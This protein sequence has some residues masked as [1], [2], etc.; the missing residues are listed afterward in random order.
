MQITV[1]DVSKLIHLILILSSKTSIMSKEY[2][3]SLV[4][5]N[6]DNQDKVLEVK[7][8]NEAIF[9]TNV[10]HPD[11]DWLR[12]ECLMLIGMV[13]I[14]RC[15]PQP[16][17]AKAK[18][19]LFERDCNKNYYMRFE[20]RNNARYIVI[21]DSYY[22]NGEDPNFTFSIPFDKCDQSSLTQVLGEIVVFKDTPQSLELE[23]AKKKK[24]EGSRET[25]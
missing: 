21:E 12:D 5:S 20:V 22:V 6:N 17:C 10:E 24:E 11:N 2:T 9:T 14:S 13:G 1:S 4:D 16:M 23:E 8:H 25:A 15:W 18:L 19:L 3:F 7:S